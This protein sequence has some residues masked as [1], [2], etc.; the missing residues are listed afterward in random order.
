MFAEREIS[1][2]MTARN[3]FTR[4]TVKRIPVSLYK[5]RFL[6]KLILRFPV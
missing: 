2:V 1:N 3:V 6:M 5:V 4:D